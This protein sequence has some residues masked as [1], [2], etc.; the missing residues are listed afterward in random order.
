[1]FRNIVLLVVFIALID[2]LSADLFSYYECGDEI[3]EINNYVFISSPN[4][5]KTIDPAER[6]LCNYMFDVS[7]SL[8]YLNS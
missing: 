6:H 3:K 2:S 5:P 1:M 7:F 4:Y 8:K